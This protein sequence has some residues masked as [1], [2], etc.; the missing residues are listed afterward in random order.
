LKISDFRLNY[1]SEHLKSEIATSEIL[2]SEIAT[3]IRTRQE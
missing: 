1:E 3:S 2:K